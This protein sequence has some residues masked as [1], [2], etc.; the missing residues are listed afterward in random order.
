M[1]T[2][3][4]CQRQCQLAYTKTIEERRQCLPRIEHR[5]R[6]ARRPAG[7]DCACSQAATTGG[8]RTART[9]AQALSGTS[10][11]TRTHERELSSAE[12]ELLSGLVRAGF[13]DASEFWRNYEVDKEAML[14]AGEFGKVRRDARLT[15]SHASTDRHGGPEDNLPDSWEGPMLP[16]LLEAVRDDTLADVNPMCPQVYAAHDKVT[17]QKVA[18]KMI[19]KHRRDRTVE[20]HIEGICNEV[21]VRAHACVCGGGAWAK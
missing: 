20:E 21:C 12:D 18:V 17:G 10:V 13:T 11:C 5:T 8:A 6:P 16:S 19:T 3:G 4:A 2:L 14:G 9:R 7:L 15:G 1:R